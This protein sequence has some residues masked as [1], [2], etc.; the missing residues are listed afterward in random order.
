M[1]DVRFRWSRGRLFRERSCSFH[2]NKW[3]MQSQVEERKPKMK[4]K[5]RAGKVAL[6]GILIALAM[7]MSFVESLIPLPVPVPGVKL[8]LANLVTIAGLYLIGI[9]GT[10]GVTVLRVVLVG[11]SF[12][13]PYSMIYG[14]SGSF[15]SLLIMAL[16][17]KYRW[18]SQV[19]IS[20]LG[21]IFHNIGQITFAALIVQTA[22]VYVYLP[23]LLIA[24]C[25]AG[26]VI[27]ILGGIMTDRL[28]NFTKNMR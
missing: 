7:V 27:G 19:G 9:P 26:A 16:A 8:G 21:G 20:I 25:I 23:V 28:T 13:N 5:D 10:I 14:L 4:E 24:G 1:L 15:L 6:Y 3:K 17:K 18:F 11:L 22:G 2:S 12:G